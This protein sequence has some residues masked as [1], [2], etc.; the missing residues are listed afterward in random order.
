M[1]NQHIL[2]QNCQPIPYNPEEKIEGKVYDVQPVEYVLTPYEQDVI[3]HMEQVRENI[4]AFANVMSLRAIAH[5]MS[6]LKGDEKSIMEANFTKLR[7]TTY[8]SKEYIALLDEIRPAL[9]LH[10]ARNDHHPEHHPNGV[11]DMDLFQLVEMLCDWK[12]A[13]EKHADGD[14][15]KSLDINK[16]RFGLSD[17]LYGI[18]RNTIL[19]WERNND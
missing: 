12:A 13:I 14:I 19:R 16:E 1:K 6:K 3:K 11:N 15:M 17:Q 4:F 2:D 5:D 9:D 18:L 10:Y 7:T 8:G